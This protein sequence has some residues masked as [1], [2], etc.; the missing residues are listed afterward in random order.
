MCERSEWEEDRSGREDLPMQSNSNFLI[1]HFED[2]FVRTP[3]QHVTMSL[4]SPNHIP[5]RLRRFQIH[6]GVFIR[7]EIGR[8]LSD[9]QLVFDVRHEDV[10]CCVETLSDSVVE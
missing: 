9:R 6:I 4:Q 5:R 1:K 3:F 8:T 10:D 2:M 7:S